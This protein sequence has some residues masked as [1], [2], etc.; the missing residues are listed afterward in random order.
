MFEEWMQ[1]LEYKL[2]EASWYDAEGCLP[3]F[4]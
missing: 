4:A 1:K 3:N 2:V